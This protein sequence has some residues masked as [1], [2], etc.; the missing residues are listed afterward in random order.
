MP[1]DFASAAQLF[2]G[3]EDE[4]ARALGL[5]VADLRALRTTPQQATPELLARMG[6]V[7]VERG[8]GMARVGEML[9]EDGRGG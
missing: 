6:G 8:R 5:A 7:L 1:L 3:T 9:Q 4:L 2:M